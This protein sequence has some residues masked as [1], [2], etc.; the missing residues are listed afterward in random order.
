M[1]HHAKHNFVMMHK[2]LPTN[3][4]KNIPDYPHTMIG[5]GGLVINKKDQILIISEKNGLI[6]GYWKL[7]GGHLDPSKLFSRI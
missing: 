1:F 3:E 5:V 2:W 7:P 4:I 6:P